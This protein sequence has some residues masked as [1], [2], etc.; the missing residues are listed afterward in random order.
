MTAVIIR[1]IESPLQRM[2]QRPAGGMKV[3]EALGAADSNLSSLQDICNA[4]LDRR[5]APILTYLARDQNQR[6]TDEE[7]AEI[8]R[9]ADAALTA[10]GALDLPMLGRALIMLC[11]LADALS[12]TDYWPAGA[13]APAIN[14]I[15]LTRASHITAPAAEALLGELHRCLACYIEHS[16]D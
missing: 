6:P 8:M 2:L 16:G 11:A 14:L 3:S 9:D 10:C 15:T 4:E 1:K 12:H 13:L 7:L 5:L